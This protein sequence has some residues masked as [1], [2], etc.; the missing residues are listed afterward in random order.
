M[1]RILIYTSP[2]RGHLFPM[3]G[4]ST[5]LVR[6]GHQVHLRTIA[7]AAD[8][9]RAAG[10]EFSP[11][12]PRIEAREMDD[13]KAKNPMAAVDLAMRTFA[14]R[15]PYEIGDVK[16][17]IAEFGPDVVVVDTNTWGAQVAAEASGLPWATFQPYFTPMPDRDVP[18]FGPGLAPAGG[19]LG[20]LR[21]RVLGPVITGKLAK[22]ML[23]VMNGMRANEGLAAV[24]D[25]ED[26]FTRAPLTLYF[27]IPELEYPRRRWPA[28]YRFVGPALGGPFAEAFDLPATDRPIVLVTCSTEQQ[29]D[30]RIVE[31]ALETL[32]QA[33]YF[34]V[35]T[36]AAHDPA[37]F[38][39]PADGAL[40]ERFLP[41]EAL[42]P[43]TAVAVGHGG[44]GITQRALAHGIPIV[45]VPFGR[46]Q[47]EV[48]RR[49]E[50]AGVGVRLPQRRLGKLDRAVGEALE[51]RGAVEPI[52][53]SMAAA[54]GDRAAAEAVEE[55]VRA[56]AR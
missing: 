44:M 52:A 10:I 14:D 35:A 42:L 43:Q 40:V 49:V 21:N 55:L 13:W 12:D 50:A 47:L 24:E 54:G 29:D 38:K 23:P 41:H 15:A 48:A 6:R 19:L 9:V 30:R 1:T 16:G 18:P 36:T 3:L 5:E 20:T 53:S 25:L 4:T 28:S 56:E 32:P 37:S 51:L 27:T 34:V 7:S 45:V 8:K 11:I 46:D 2:A 26:A 33:G 17:A 39:A 22:L 31:A